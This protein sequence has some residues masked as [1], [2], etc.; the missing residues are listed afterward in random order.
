MSQHTGMNPFY[1]LIV[2]MLPMLISLS[3]FSD[4]HLGNT[5]QRPPSPN[6]KMAICTVDIVNIYNLIWKKS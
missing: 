5:H 1:F 6:V 4:G 3:S 2:L